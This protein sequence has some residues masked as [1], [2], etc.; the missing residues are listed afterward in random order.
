MYLNSNI[1][2]YAIN[3]SELNIPNFD[4]FLNLLDPNAQIICGVRDPI[5]I[6]KH[7]WGRD[8]TKVSRN[9]PRDFNLTYDYRNYIEFLTHNKK[10]EIKVDFEELNNG[11]FILNFLLRY[12]NQDK[13]YYLD[14]NSI[15]PDNAFKTLDFLARKFSFTPPHYRKTIFF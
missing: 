10:T 2:Q 15:I 7:N 8:W 4:K 12:F 5:G 6:L 13:I 9:Y 11:V 3:I 1:D 14:M